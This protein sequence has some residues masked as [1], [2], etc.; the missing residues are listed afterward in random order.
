MIGSMP[1]KD[2]RRACELVAHYLKDIPAWPQLPS[3]RPEEGM[4]AQFGEGFPALSLA[5]NK[6]AV[7]TTRDLSRGLE[8]IYAA[9]LDGNAGAFPVSEEHAAGLYEFLKCTNLRPLAVKGQVTGPISFGL[10]VL[11]ASGKAIIYDDTLADAAAKLLHL[12][13]RWQERELSRLSRRTIIF[14]DEPGMASYGSAFFNLP[15]ERIT[16]LIND[17]LDG[18]TGLKGIHCCGNTDWGLVVS[19]KADILSFDAYNYGGSLSLFPNEVRSFIKGG[20]AVAWGI[21]P[22]T[23]ALNKES[24]ASLKD[25]LEDGMAPFT[26][27]GVSFSQLKEQ[28]VLTPSCSLAAL[29]EDGAEQALKTLTALSARMRGE[30]AP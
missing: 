24:V 20:G 17:T 13:A 4:V 23:E 12:K 29:T 11:D 5:E 19:T 22:N 8:A 14:V 27:L 30:S 7:D 28:A 16:A 6:I 3:R 25:R 21:V 15:K 9:Y 1:H 26:R 18:I 10:S 2:P